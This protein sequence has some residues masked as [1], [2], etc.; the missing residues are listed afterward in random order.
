[1][2]RD[3]PNKQEVSLPSTSVFVFALL[4]SFY[5]LRQYKSKAATYGNL[6]LYEYIDRII[7]IEYEKSSIQCKYNILNISFR[8]LNFSFVLFRRRVLNNFKNLILLLMHVVPGITGTK[9]FLNY[10]LL[11]NKHHNV[12]QRAVCHYYSPPITTTAG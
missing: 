3:Y 10:V 2:S 11:T 4:N 6:N 12:K 9:Y 8:F 1:M 5:D 7:S